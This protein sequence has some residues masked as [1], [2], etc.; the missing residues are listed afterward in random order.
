MINVT[1]T[2]QY[3]CDT[4]AEVDWVVAQIPP[5]YK[6]TVDK[7]TKTVTYQAKQTTEAA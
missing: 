5:E 7:L 6:P 1:A 3:K 2:Y 4:Q